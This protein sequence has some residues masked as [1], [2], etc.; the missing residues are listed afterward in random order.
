M[1]INPVTAISQL[2][3]ARLANANARTPQPPPA[4]GVAATNEPNVGPLPKP[5]AQPPQKAAASAELPQDEVHVQR[6]SQAD[7]DIVVRYTDHT[8]NLILQ[9]PDAE[10]LDVTRAINQEF[11]AEAK[12]RAAAVQAENKGGQSHGH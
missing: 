11:R 7:G 6:D 1:S 3:E 10:V 2:V 9:V 5:E 4:Q 8:G 12:A